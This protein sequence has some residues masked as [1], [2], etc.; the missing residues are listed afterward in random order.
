MERK[1]R[2]KKEVSKFF[3]SILVGFGVVIVVALTP[4][5]FLSSAHL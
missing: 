2:Q 1:N 4:A 5:F 3:T